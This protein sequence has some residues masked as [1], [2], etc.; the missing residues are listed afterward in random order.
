MAWGKKY[1]SQFIQLVLHS[2]SAVCPITLSSL[3]YTVLY[4]V[5]GHLGCCRV[6]GPMVWQSGDGNTCWRAWDMARRTAGATYN[7]QLRWENLPSEFLPLTCTT[8]KN[9]RKGN[10]K[11]AG[12]KQVPHPPHPPPC[13]EL[14]GVITAQRSP[15]DATSVSNC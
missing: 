2:S 4:F 9:H 12:D 5:K 15:A 6:D 14:A 7:R 11:V 3:P 8:H 13:G 10:L 1:L